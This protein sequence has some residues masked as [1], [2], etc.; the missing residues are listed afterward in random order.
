[1]SETTYEFVKDGEVFTRKESE[2]TQEEQDLLLGELIHKW[3]KSPSVVRTRFLQ[4]GI[5]AH[6][7]HKQTAMNEFWKKINQNK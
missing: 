2:L 6:E 5:D 1:M 4:S 3:N 7:K